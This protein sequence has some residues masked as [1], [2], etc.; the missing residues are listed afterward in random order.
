MFEPGFFV[1]S[2]HWSFSSRGIAIP[3]HFFEFPLN[4]LLKRWVSLKFTREAAHDLANAKFKRLEQEP[5]QV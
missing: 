5:R 1:L 4:F 2:R 3:G